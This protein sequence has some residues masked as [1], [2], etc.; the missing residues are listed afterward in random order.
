MKPDWPTLTHGERVAALK[1]LLLDGY[2]YW[3]IATAFEN[4]TKNA[5]LG[6]C[7]RIGL[8]RDNAHTFT[9]PAGRDGFRANVRKEKETV[10]RGSNSYRSAVERNNATDTETHALIEEINASGFYTYDIADVAG[11]G[12]CTISNWRVGRYSA[13]AFQRQCVREALARLRAD[14]GLRLRSDRPV[15]REVLSGV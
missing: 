10:A 6:F 15:P 2:Y 8:R 9:L 3:E 14:P 11:V 1:P 5:V 12:R 7:Y 13:R 4:A